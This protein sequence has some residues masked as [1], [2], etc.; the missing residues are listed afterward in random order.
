MLKKQKKTSWLPA[1]KAKKSKAKKGAMIGLGVTG[2]IG[3][4]VAGLSKKQPRL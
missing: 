4:L 3:A 2:A 1:P